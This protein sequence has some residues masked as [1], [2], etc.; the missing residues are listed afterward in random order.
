MIILGINGLGVSPAACLCI[1]GR[2]V[3]MA[4][5]ER[6]IRVKGA[7]GLMPGL[8]ARYCLEHARMTLDDVDYI[9]FGWDAERYRLQIPLFAARTLFRR[10]SELPDP[11][12]AAR[13]VDQL[14]KY[15]PAAVMQALHQM[16]HAA[17]IPGRLP[18]VEFV[19]HHLAHAASAFYCSGFDKAHVLV[20][21]GSG[22]H[23]C[24]TVYRGAGRSLHEVLSFTIPDSLGWF[25]QA[26]TE[27]LG[28]T[29]NRHEGK[30]MALASYGSPD[31]D[32]RERLGRIIWSGCPGRYKHDGRYSYLGKHS[33]GTVFSEKMAR[34]L[35]APRV[36]GE[37]IT[38][39]HENIAFMAQ[40]ILEDIAGGLVARISTMDDYSGN[41]C[42]AGGVALNC[43][44]NGVLAAMEQ[45]Q[46]LYVPAAPNDAGTAL[47]AALHLSNERGADPRRPLDHAYWG[48]EFSAREI[49]DALVR[50]GARYRHDP[51]V[52]KTVAGLL[53]N[54]K[55]VGWYQGRME[56]GA[57]ALGSRS[58]LANPAEVGMKDRVN[59]RV[60]GRE[61]WR[62][63]APSILRE[64]APDY[65]ER[66]GRAPF[67]ATAFKA[68]KE[69]LGSLSAAVHVDETTRPQ[70]VTREHSP[71]YWELIRC[72]GEETGTHAVLNTS[73]NAS[74]E[75]IV[76]T[77][78]QAL[79]TFYASGMDCLAV[80]GFLVT[81]QGEQEGG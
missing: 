27:F 73:F 33:R 59:T 10:P 51:N 66:L 64:K 70:I 16:C 23:Q 63:F 32:L 76:C 13:V 31:P 39:R 58:I 46:D 9:A 48:P 41:L 78:E 67:M 24:T 60:K 55:I 71:K 52:E 43:K 68:R 30:V 53:A 22:E 49:E 35:G 17:A 80:G 65:I 56:I 34:L 21:D 4:E 15:R 69:A 2:L 75:P 11:G 81:K 79:R 40:S 8:A 57:R 3:A 72:F 77:P 1:D 20:V 62:P 61:R 26:V 36:A 47:G 29:P 45:V 37:P 54:G 74:E 12:N 50:C 25:Y 5:E 6:L 14:L 42:V 18:P 44:M 19:P 38:G 28:F 7:H